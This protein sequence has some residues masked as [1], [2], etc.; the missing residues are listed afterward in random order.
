[1]ENYS[2]LMAVYHK[3]KAE[4]L[5]VAIESML[6]QSVP[7][8]D[9]VLVCD[10]HLTQELDA[11]VRA[12]EA[13]YPALFQI[14]R[15]AENRG[16]G[17]A[18]RTG[19]PYCKFELVARMDAD[20]IALP[21]RME[22]QLAAMVA[23]PRLSALGGQIGEFDED[24][25]RVIAYRLVPTEEE[26]LRE[27]LK[28]RSPMNHVTVVFRKSHV[29]RAGSYPDVPG[30]EDYCL[31]TRLIAAGGQLRNLPD[32]CCKVRV[33]DAMY[34]RRGGMGYFRSTL[35]L[36]RLLLETRNIYP[37]QFCKNLAVRFFAT[38]LIP[39]KIRKG[40]FLRLLRKQCLDVAWE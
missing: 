22:K 6:G 34:A 29:L 4:H 39:A 25:E 8:A 28:Y 33:N 36:E 24:P 10:G 18:L 32:V 5:R 35:R 26:K 12:F 2:V 21:D 17:A 13:E 9:F 30:F 14:L 23:C 20:D 15:L 19:L 27:F 16:L 1:M 37:V 11:M 40:L 38:L 3:D 31:W 7:P